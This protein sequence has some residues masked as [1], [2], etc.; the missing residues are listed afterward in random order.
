MIL[1]AAVNQAGPRLG[2][3]GQRLPILPTLEKS[4][5]S[6]WLDFLC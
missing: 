6:V 3:L 1:V 4:A 5:R 2:I